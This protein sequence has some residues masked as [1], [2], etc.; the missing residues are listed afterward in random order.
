MF[1]GKTFHKIIMGQSIKSLRLMVG[2]L[3]WEFLAMAIVE[4]RFGDNGNGVLFSKKKKL[5][6]FFFD[7]NG[8]IFHHFHDLCGYLQCPLSVSLL[9]QPRLVNKE[10]VFRGSWLLR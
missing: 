6:F 10:F 8:H 5:I 2:Y 3:V 9:L 4:S 1:V 7:F